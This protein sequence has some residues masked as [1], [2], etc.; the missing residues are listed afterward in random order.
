MKSSTHASTKQSRQLVF[1]TIIMG[2]E[3]WVPVP[4]GSCSQPVKVITA[5]GHGLQRHGINHPGDW[6]IYM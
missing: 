3:L 4:A 1:K 5:L 2:R 6:T